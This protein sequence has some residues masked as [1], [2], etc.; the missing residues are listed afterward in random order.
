MSI[1]D[2]ARQTVRARANFR[3]EYCEVGED[4]TGGELTIDHY[5]PQSAGGADDLDNL[6]YACYRCNLYKSDYWK[7]GEI[8]RRIINPRL[9]SAAK[10]FWL[11]PNGNLYALSEPAKFTIERLRLNRSA[12]VRHRRQKIELLGE[13]ERFEQMRQTVRLLKQTGEQ[14]NKLLAEQQKQLR[15]QKE[16]LDILLNLDDE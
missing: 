2:E 16:L 5:Q 13:R 14:K 9:E 15:E 6:V 3:C 12:L 8:D 11:S 4:D 1:S 10:H 7:A